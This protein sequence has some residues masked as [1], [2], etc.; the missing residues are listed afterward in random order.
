MLWG[1]LSDFRSC[2]VKLTSSKL[3]QGVPPIYCKER[4]NSDGLKGFIRLWI[5]WFSHTHNERL[6]QLRTPVETFTLNSS[7]FRCFNLETWIDE[8]LSLR[9]FFLLGFVS[10]SKVMWPSSPFQALIT[11]EVSNL[12]TLHQSQLQP[13]FELDLC[14]GKIFKLNLWNSKRLFV[15]II[16][17]NGL[18]VPHRLRLRP[19]YHHMAPKH[20]TAAR[21]YLCLTL[22]PW[23]PPRLW[24]T[25]HHSHLM[26]VWV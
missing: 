20:L 11:T 14:L 15:I 17:L 8:H 6:H 21:L 10:V 19:V 26:A 13:F 24:F 23:L 18:R 5:L 16:G 12:T 22:S 25:G 7:G 2:S 1:G 9:T 3:V 4:I